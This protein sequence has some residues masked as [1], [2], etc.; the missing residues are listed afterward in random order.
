MGKRTPDWPDYPKWTTAK[1]W[2]FLRSG[3]R[4][5]FNRWPPKYECLEKAKRTVSGQRHR[6][7]YQCAECEGWF[8]QKDVEVDHIT[9]V[10]SLNNY[11]DLV[12]FVKRMFVSTDKLRVVC[13]TCHKAKT[14]GSKK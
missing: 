9:P 8:K 13:K 3:F 2:S 6:Y 11:D 12:G 1:F 7:E 14:Y 5:K 4:Q 10:G